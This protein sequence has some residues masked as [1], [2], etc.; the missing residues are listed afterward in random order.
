MS[1]DSLD[2]VAALRNG[3]FIIQR[4]QWIDDKLHWHGEFA[5]NDLTRRFALSPQQAS[6]DI[7][8]YLDIAPGNA[9][10]HAGTKAYVKPDSYRPIF[11]KDAFRW[12][13]EAKEKGD[14]SVIPCEALTLPSRQ[15]DDAALAAAMASFASRQ[16]LAISY[17]SLT[18]SEVTHRKICPHHV[19]DTGDRVHLRAWDD[20]RRLF[21]DFVVGR[22]LL[23]EIEPDYPWVDGIA[24]TE[25][26]ETV[27]V[28]LAPDQRLSPSQMAAIERE[29]RMRNG[30][31]SV[32]VRKALLVYVL[33]RL[34]L[35]EAVRRGAQAPSASRGIRCLNP[36]DLRPF[37][38]RTAAD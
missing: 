32:E 5:R 16:A 35:L 27:E 30:K 4:L 6:A 26:N 29:F 19:V 17:Q 1:I 34:G 20:R 12:M 18:T 36:A 25:W 2:D 11:T 8:M 22:I 9:R 21:A 3:S 28:H 7:A 10:L 13:V 15:V 14:A 37:L 24:D 33:G 31:L 23:A 38:P